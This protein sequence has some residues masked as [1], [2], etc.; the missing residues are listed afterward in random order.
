[1]QPSYSNP[2][3]SNSN[4]FAQASA[5]SGFKFSTIG[6]NPSLLER[7]GDGP[8]AS[9]R[10]PSSDQNPSQ[11]HNSA[12]ASHIPFRPTSP[13]PLRVAP[14]Y[15]GSSVKPILAQDLN[16]PAPAS[17]SF[18]PFEPLDDLKIHSQPLDQKRTSV[19]PDLQYPNA[20]PGIDSPLRESF[21][22]PSRSVPHKRD[23]SHQPQPPIGQNLSPIPVSNLPGIESGVPGEVTGSPAPSLPSA[24]SQHSS[25]TPSTEPEHVRRPVEHLFKLAS[26]RE[27]H[28]SR[29]RETFDLRSGELS[30]FGAEALQAVQ[31]LQDRTETLKQQAEDM[32]AQA[33]QTLQEATKMRDMADQLIASAGTLG[34]DLLGAQVSRAV[35]RSEQLTRFVQKGFDWLSNLRSREQEK[36]AVVQAEIAEQDLADLQRRQQELQQQLERRKIEEQE[37]M[38]AA[39]REEQ[40]R[41]AA[42]KNAEEE[43]ET[44]RMRAYDIRRAEVMAEK[45]RATEAQAQSIQAEREKR[46]ADA[47]GSGLRPPTRSSDTPLGTTPTPSSEVVH[48]IRV[49]ADVPSSQVTV[50]ALPRSPVIRT[51][52]PPEITS[53]SSHSQPQP[54]KVKTVPA[55][56]SFVPAQTEAGR[57][58]N[59]DSPLSS[60]ILASELHPRN[61]V[62]ASRHSH[63]NQV[64]RDAQDE[65]QPQNPRQAA[66]PKEVHHVQ[67][68]RE[69]SVGVLPRSYPQLS[70]NMEHTD[71]SQHHQPVAVLRTPS[72]G[73]DIDQH[74]TAPSTSEPR[75][76]PPHVVQTD[77]YLRRTDPPGSVPYQDE[78]RI[79][80]DS[81]HDQVAPSTDRRALIRQDSASSELSA[82]NW[83]YRDRRSPS[84]LSSRE[85]RSRS[86]SPPHW[87]KRTRS[88]TPPRF[89][90]RQNV[91]HWGLDRPRV[92]PRIDEDRDRSWRYNGYD[93]RR[94]G[95]SPRRYLAPPPRRGYNSYRPSHSPPPSPRRLRTER[96]PPRRSYPD[97]SL[98]AEHVPQRFFNTD[99]RERRTDEYRADVNAH[100]NEPAAKAYRSVEKEEQ[101]TWQQQ[102]YQRRTPSPSERDPTLTPPPRQGEAD[103]GL[104]DRINMNEADNRGPGR[105]RVVARGGPNPRRGTRGVPSGGR[106]RSGAL[107]LLSRMSE[108]ATRSTRTAPALSL[109][110]RMQQD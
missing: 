68:K 73:L 88:R 35:G 108:T 70:P 27:E 91:D 3:V 23:A 110:D 41:E 84:R 50:P 39:K 95:D 74:I 61:V 98:G 45:R 64:T 30:T 85:G 99:V 5:L 104:L 21:I 77:G 103:I 19:F 105:G 71:Q 83:N 17:T 24:S 54:H 37:N 97:R 20:T 109:S 67:V 8:R 60:T 66:P 53:P 56:V 51:S 15:R 4:S 65:M 25:T 52:G 57:A 55:P 72:Q 89:E 96:S 11:V 80:Q 12:S 92:R 62:E 79:V 48:S 18:S 101:Q 69:P 100:H 38:E 1:M 43:R 46:V 106:G 10:P 13:L 26:V 16:G 107:A 76:T 7:M 75:A 86:R 14:V 78:P 93:R 44:A 47:S 82:Q 40:E 90:T 94:R 81:H 32:R 34:V 58:V 87:R 102:T 29:R 36:I 31:D 59:T 9:L 42:R 22:R 6:N 33:E 63:L 49:S 2:P 28:L